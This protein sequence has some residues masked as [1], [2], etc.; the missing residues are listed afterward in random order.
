MIISEKENVPNGFRKWSLSHPVAGNDDDQPGGAT[1]IA[2]TEP[3]R[4]A[5]ELRYSA[6]AGSF[7]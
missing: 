7:S 5:G 6:V 3:V 1:P 4:Q 2:L